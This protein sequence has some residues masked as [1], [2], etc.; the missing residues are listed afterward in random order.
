[1]EFKLLG[2]MEV[3]SDGTPV[4]IRAYRQESVLALL[5]LEA[6]HVVSVDRLVD[7]V[8]GDTPPR[9][10][11]NQVH[12]TI[13]ALR[14]LVGPALI[15]TRPPGYLIRISPEACDLTLYQRLAARASQAAQ[16]QRLLDAMQDLRSALALW[17]GPALDGVR[18]DIAR[19]AAL[20][21]FLHLL[22]G[23]TDG[24]WARL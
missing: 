9:T 17:R 21:R 15:A 8:W 6:N 2:P 18:G 14:Q 24:D 10:A 3:I 7:G 11:K 5:L 20:V 23:A 19:A 4:A 13:S 22:P 16:E 1:M 12:I